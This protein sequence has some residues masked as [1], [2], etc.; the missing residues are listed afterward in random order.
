MRDYGLVVVTRAG[1][2]PQQFI[3]NSDL[4]SK[5]QV[6]ETLNWDEWWISSLRGKIM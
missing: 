6:R 5:Y 4:L 3:Y 2:D 1:S